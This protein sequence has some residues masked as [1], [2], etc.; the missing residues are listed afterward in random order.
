ML[1]DLTCKHFHNF[2]K[3]LKC[4]KELLCASVDLW[5]YTAEVN[6]TF[7]HIGTEKRLSTVT[8][9]DSLLTPVSMLGSFTSCYSKVT[10]AVS[11]Y[12][13]GEALLLF[14]LCAIHI[15]WANLQ[16][17]SG[18]IPHTHHKTETLWLKSLNSYLKYMGML[19]GTKCFRNINKI[20]PMK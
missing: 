9:K 8:W 5:R 4:L 10:L 2:A 12:G 13:F 1:L 14:F 16:T 20:I 18:F 15:W 3:I 19:E 11:F 6:I 17:Y 7:I